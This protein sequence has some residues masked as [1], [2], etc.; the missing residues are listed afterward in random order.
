MLIKELYKHV[1]FVSN[2]TL[3][4]RMGEFALNLALLSQSLWSGVLDLGLGFS[5]VDRGWT[6]SPPC[7]QY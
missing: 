6:S 7:T 3:Q 2:Y 4:W 5:Y 1:I